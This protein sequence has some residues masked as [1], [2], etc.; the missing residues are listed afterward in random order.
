MSI[1][2]LRYLCLADL[3]QRMGW[4]SA[5]HLVTLIANDTS[6]PRLSE[7]N[8]VGF[9]PVLIVFGDRDNTRSWSYLVSPYG[10]VLNFNEGAPLPDPYGMPP[11]GP[12]APPSLLPS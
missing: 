5:D 9:E 4:D 11:D 7:L 3:C 12:G 1:G 10:R 6:G 2:A 8:H